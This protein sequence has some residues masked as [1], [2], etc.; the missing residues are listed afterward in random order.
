[1][2][3]VIDVESGAI[4]RVVHWDDV[5]CVFIITPVHSYGGRWN[6]M[7]YDGVKNEVIRPLT[8]EEKGDFFNYLLQKHIKGRQ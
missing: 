7:T 4:C 6:D 8:E 3:L 5:D 1:M 2:K